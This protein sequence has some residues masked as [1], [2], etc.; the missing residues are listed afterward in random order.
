MGCCQ[1]HERALLGD[2][3]CTRDSQVRFA[4]AGFFNST[5]FP[6]LLKRWWKPPSGKKNK[7]KV[8]MEEFARICVKQKIRAEMRKVASILARPDDPL[9]LETLTS[10]NF[11]EL[12]KD[13][14]KAAPVLWNVLHEAAWST[15]QAKRNTDKS[16]DN[17]S[18]SLLFG[19][20][21][22][23]MNVISMLSYTRSHHSCRLAALWAIYLKSC[24]LSSRAFDAV[25]ATGLAMSIR[26]TNDAFKTISD[27]QMESAVVAV[28]QRT[29]TLSY[30]NVNIPKRVFSMRTTNQNQFYSACAATLWVLPEYVH[31]PEDLG[32]EFRVA[33]REGATEPFNIED[34]LDGDA[35]DAAD[36]RIA[37]SA[38]HRILRFLLDAPAFESYSHKDHPILLPPP[39][40]DQLPAGPE[41]TTKQF[42]LY[43]ADIEEASYDGNRQA[44]EEW[45]RQLGLSGEKL[46]LATDF[47]IAFIGDQLTVERLRGLM[48]Y[49]HKDING[50]ERLDWVLPVFGWLHLLFAF[51]ASILGQYEGTSAG[52]GLRRAF[53]LL[54]RKG[55]QKTL[56]KGPFWHHLDEA[57]WHIGE[58]HILACWTRTAG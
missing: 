36:A 53:D 11:V 44:V 37:A 5:E 54:K 39:P 14:A 55:L 3:E 25:H 10:L 58:A 23:I 6:R 31:L 13:L 17:V 9:S 1:V 35:Q 21:C 50:Y 27:R 4:R 2:A 28:K 16:P 26:W 56:T 18:A 24:G 52:Y 12:S 19:L 45:L 38:K 34:L 33:R 7:S 15:S 47:V 57:L 30:D 8:R 51:A 42:M 49:R 22:V 20:C 41:H 43:T 29:W 48:R 40:T 32:H 46:R